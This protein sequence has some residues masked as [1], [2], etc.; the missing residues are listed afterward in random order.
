MPFRTVMKTSEWLEKCKLELEAC[1]DFRIYLVLIFSS[2]VVSL[3]VALALVFCACESER[4][5]A[6]TYAERLRLYE[7]NPR[8]IQRRRQDMPPTYVQAI[9]TQRAYRIPPPPY[10]ETAT[11]PLA[12]EA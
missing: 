5:R 4:S 7:G 12:L 3:L 9:S 6:N 10:T 11:R 1:Q 8:L 2:V